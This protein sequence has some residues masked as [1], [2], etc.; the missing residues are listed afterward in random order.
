VICIIIHEL[1]HSTLSIMSIQTQQNLQWM[2][3][4]ISVS[5]TNPRSDMQKPIATFTA[6]DI[7][8]YGC[9]SSLRNAEATWSLPTLVQSKRLRS[10][11][12]AMGNVF[13]SALRSNGRCATPTAR[14]TPFSLPL[15]NRRVYRGA[16][17]KLLQQI[18]YN[19]FVGFRNTFLV[20]LQNWRITFLWHEVGYQKESISRCT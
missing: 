3:S 8:R 9:V 15:R 20:G 1:Q 10:C 5:P 11:R 18:R 4:V 17:W 7:A 6:A 12:P 14:K 16:A 2:L 13:T 19:T